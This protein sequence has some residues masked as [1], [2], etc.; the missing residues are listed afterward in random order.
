MFA[1]ELGEEFV[2]NASA[3]GGEYLY[4]FAE[5]ENIAYRD[6]RTWPFVTLDVSMCDSLEIRWKSAPVVVL[7]DDVVLASDTGGRGKVDRL[8]IPTLLMGGLQ[9][10]SELPLGSALR[11]R[12]ACLALVV[13]IRGRTTQLPTYLL[14]LRML[15]LARMP[16][17]LWHRRPGMIARDG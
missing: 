4:L 10:T 2:R 6:E 3:I 5:D 13:V 8:E 11:L 7:C 15:R 14:W 9:C 17:L 16:R 1:N 12:R